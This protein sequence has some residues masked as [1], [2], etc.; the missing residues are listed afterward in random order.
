[1]RGAR[2][3]GASARLAAALVPAAAAWLCVASAAVRSESASPDA[4]ASV[5]GFAPHEALRLGQRIYREG[6]G[7]DGRAVTAIVAGD[8]AVDGT[9]LTCVSC[10][11]RSGIGSREASVVA[12]PVTGKELSVPRRRA[13]AWNPTKQH[14]GPGAVERWSLP[15][16]FREMADLRPAYTD[17]TL[18][19]VLRTGVDSGG[20]VLNRAMP[21]FELTE[22]DEAVLLHYLESLSEDLSPGVDDEA[23]RFAT[24]VTEGV[25]QA[26]RDA[27]LAV[28]Q[29]HVDAHNTQTR[30]YERRAKTG[31]FYKTE[32]YGAYRKLA[33]DVWEL[34]G[35]PDTW[36]QQLE[37]RY[38]QRPVFAL[39]GGIAAGSW[40]PIHEFAE[41]RRLPA[42]LPVTER[43]V[44]SETDWYTLYFSKGPYQEGEAAARF[45]GRNV[46]AGRPVR[47]LQVYRIGTAGEDAA[48]GFQETWGRLGETGLVSRPLDP[49]EDAAT[50]LELDPGKGSGSA[51][52]VLWLEGE[53]LAEALRHALAPTDGIEAVFASWRLATSDLGGLPEAARK[54]LYLT[55]PYTLP[56]ERERRQRIVDRWLKAR[57]ISGVSPA[58]EAQ[59]YFLGWMLPGAIGALRNEF[60]RDYFLEAF[61]MMQDQ[62]YAI[63][64][65]HRLSFGPDQ[66]Y[67]AKG[68]Y[69]VQLSADDAPRLMPASDWVIN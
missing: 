19:R 8:A 53:E 54:R 56:E 15:P 31:P 27:M 55:Y 66:R 29:A 5:A 34:E 16:R 46:G 69:I 67:L 20:R 62:D 23:I 12:W 3:V 13:G 68:C 43:P 1:M 35:P 36:R 2:V 6:I 11:R 37:A 18:A 38:A 48:R 47:V 26:D 22:R 24:V 44:V 42:I 50:A 45:V 58:V 59:M 51:I 64:L 9:T 60:Y 32:R 17:E 39:L 33:L 14:E 63:P 10:H 41:E 65:Y 40:G 49:G 4:P 52:L 25:P 7:V 21:R 28:L 57:G 30:P 61:E